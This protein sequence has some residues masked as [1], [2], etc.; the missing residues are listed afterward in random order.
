V[1]RTRAAATSGP[2]PARGRAADPYERA[3]AAYRHD[4]EQRETDFS[5]RQNEGASRFD[6]E[7]GRLSP[8]EQAD[9]S[10]DA[11]QQAAPRGSHAA[12]SARSYDHSTRTYREDPYGHRSGREANSSPRLDP[13]KPRSLQDPALTNSPPRDDSR[14][15]PV[16]RKATSRHAYSE[17][18]YYR[19][20]DLGPGQTHET[21]K[22]GS[23]SHDRYERR[24]R[25]AAAAAN[26]SGG[27]SPNRSDNY[28]TVADGEPRMRM[29]TRSPHTR[30]ATTYRTQQSYGHPEEIDR[31]PY[32]SR[33][34]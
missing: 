23:P 13:G 19:A 31:T 28:R 33:G 24:N 29:R 7:S 5:R 3:E 26:S 2:G 9:Y 22:S 15:T 10:R 25:A 6:P 21:T 17:S 1:Y 30:E 34:Y 27:R 16:E 32:S 12:G 8:R 14:L 18:T 11:P 20:G 4:N